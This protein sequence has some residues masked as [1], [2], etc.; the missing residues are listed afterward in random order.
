MY[1]NYL[2]SPFW[3]MGRSAY[4]ICFIRVKSNKGHPLERTYYQKRGSKQIETNTIKVQFEIAIAAASIRQASCYQNKLSLKQHQHLIS[5]RWKRAKLTHE[6]ALPI[7]K[8]ILTRCTNSFVV[9]NV[10]IKEKSTGAKYL[11]TYYFQSK[12]H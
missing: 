6:K 3:Y 2:V 1:Y 7:E 8:C 11:L 12:W 4:K 10:R 9:M 5:K